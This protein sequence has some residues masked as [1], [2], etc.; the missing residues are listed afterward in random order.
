MAQ[1]LER[2]TANI[3]K[4]YPL[5]RYTTDNYTLATQNID[6][7]LRYFYRYN[8]AWQRPYEDQFLGN[9]A[10]PHF[11]QVFEYERNI[12]LHLGFRQYD[13]YLFHP[14][15]TPYFHTPYPYARF[16]YTLGGSEEQLLIASFAQTIRKRLHYTL[17]Y[18]RII[19]AETYQRQQANFHN[20]VGS[21]WYENANKR[22]NV[23]SHYV[24]NSGS[25]DQSG[26]I[27]TLFKVEYDE[28]GIIESLLPK[29]LFL[30]TSVIR[31]NILDVNLENAN[32]TYKNNNFFVQHSYDWGTTKRWYES[33]ASGRD[34]IER[35]RFLPALRIGNSFTFNQTRYLY[36]DQS[37]TAN[38]YN[39]FFLNPSNIPT[40]ASIY[41]TPLQ[42]NDFKNEVFVLLMGNKK[43]EIDEG[44]YRR[45]IT[46]RASFEHHFYRIT[47]PDSVYTIQ[48]RTSATADPLTVY[49]RADQ[50]ETLQSALLN[51]YVNNP[52][53]QALSYQLHARYALWGFNL[54]DMSLDARLQYQLSRKVGGIKGRFAFKRLEADR[55]QSRWFGN[56]FDWNNDFSKTTSLQI[57]GTYFNPALKLE[58][59]YRNHTFDNYLI[60]NEEAQPEQL[61]KAVNISQFIL[62]K[63][64]KIGRFHLDNTVVYQV[65][66]N[67]SIALPTLWT[68]HQLYYQNYLFNNALYAQI[69]LDVRYNTNYYANAYAPA[70]GQFY[71]QNSNLLQ[72]YPRLDFYVSFRVKRARIY[73]LVRHLNQGLP[74]QMGYFA[75]PF[76]PMPDRSFNFGLSWL[77]YD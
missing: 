63:D 57:S 74:G 26:G 20:F 17:H 52:A 50:R 59:T 54:A 23:L 27:D 16:E 62:K 73:G 40:G 6:T 8:P 77:F 42:V 32:T 30:D 46:A 72:Y 48:R 56:H 70:T 21:I 3:E 4:R 43:D 39:S 44:E 9:L 45:T 33:T 10:Q 25:V 60:W 67:D 2:D 68:R 47:Q 51:F 22:Y 64:F 1:L 58:A 15:E 7:S 41:Y 38:Y 12:G 36:N 49:I 55:I 29:T 76:Y 18:R 34:S 31:K 75:A 19:G 69:G 66:T 71:Y 24:V 61:S 11:S 13:Q 28:F 37:P 5:M 65:S 14:E 53:S 35:K